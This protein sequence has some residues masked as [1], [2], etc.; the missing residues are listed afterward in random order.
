MKRSPAAA[1]EAVDLPRFAA[2]VV[3]GQRA[4]TLEASHATAARLFSEDPSKTKHT[5]IFTAPTKEDARLLSVRG[6]V[7]SSAGFKS[8]F[9]LEW[10]PAG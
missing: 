6:S 4:I 7:V 10:R 5:A 9:Q 8:A 2:Y 1:V 3:I